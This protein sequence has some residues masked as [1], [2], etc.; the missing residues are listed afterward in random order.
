M[1]ER[2]LV[3]SA[4]GFLGT[5]DGQR[6]AICGYSVL[7]TL[8]LLSYPGGA[9]ALVIGIP[10]LFFVP[11]FALV[12]LFFWKGT[13]IEAKFV[14]SL[15]LSI[16]AVIFLALFLVLTPI[17]L[18]Q[19]TTRA[20]L[21]AFTTGA[22]AIEAF[23]RPAKTSANEG[24]SV[25]PAEPMDKKVKLDLSIAAMIVAAMVVSVIS[26]GMVIT[27][28]Y[29]STTYFAITD[30]TG[31]ANINTSRPYNTTF[32][33]IVH[34]KNGEDGPATFRMVAYNLTLFGEHANSSLLEKG[35]TWEVPV[36]VDLIY[37]GV[38]RIDFDLYITEEGQQEYLY[39]NLH[40]WV[41]VE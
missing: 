26:L 20:S 32:S 9:F 17:G 6:L 14:L 4:V 24:K 29:P 7:A 5:E 3:D 33:V 41:N 27:A 40:L 8:L 19:D 23:I 12:R 2:S 37:Y 13:S 10:L 28:H 1:G 16:M 15:G 39:G 11:G 25:P 30:E 31:S 35:Q 34:M 36:D 38:F 21:V 22:V 18:D